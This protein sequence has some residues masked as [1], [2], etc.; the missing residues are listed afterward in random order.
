MKSTLVLLL[1]TAAYGAVAEAAL[2][3]GKREC[4][5]PY[6]AQKSLYL[7]H[8]SY[9]ARAQQ[10]ASRARKR[11]GIDEAAAARA[12]AERYPELGITRLRTE[13]IRCGV[14]LTGCAGDNRYYFDA[15]TLELLKTEAD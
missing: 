5:D 1:C 14:Y 3:L 4:R 10:L 6:R 12:V 11:F 9:L 8:T 2:Q 13:V 15:A 7:S